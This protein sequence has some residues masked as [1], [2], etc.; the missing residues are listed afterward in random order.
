MDNA[1]HDLTGAGAGGGKGSGFRGGCPKDRPKRSPKI[2]PKSKAWWPKTVAQRC[3]KNVTLKC[4]KS[5]VQKEFFFTL[6]G[7]WSKK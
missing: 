7:K 3:A 2:C 1:T 6:K 4:A 5:E